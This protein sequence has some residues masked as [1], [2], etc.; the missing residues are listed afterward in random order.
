MT[1]DPQRSQRGAILIAAMVALAIIA[2]TLKEIVTLS[3]EDADTVHLQR[4]SDQNRSYM[5]SAENLIINLLGQSDSFDHELMWAA[6]RGH[7]ILYPLDDGGMLTIQ[8]KDD[9]QCL[10]L[11]QF[12]AT[13]TPTPVQGMFKSK[14]ELAEF[15]RIVKKQLALLPSFGFKSMN[16]RAIDL[17]TVELI[18]KLADWIDADSITRTNGAETPQYMRDTPSRTAANELMADLSEI[19]L[20]QPYSYSR[21]AGLLDLAWCALPTTDDQGIGIN[22]I[23]PQTLPLLAAKLEGI[24]SVSDIKRW[25]E[26]YNGEIYERR[27]D[28][29]EAI[30]GESVLNLN[31]APADVSKINRG[32]SIHPKYITALIAVRSHNTTSFYES[33]MTIGGSDR[34][35]YLRR[36]LP[37][38]PIRE[39]ED[40]SNL[41]FDGN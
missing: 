3:K 37:Y 14:E 32:L 4:G 41:K 30:A 33:R 15:P 8:V 25:Y 36:E 19:N 9:H 39:D 6:L 12:Y 1:K 7:P 11:N 40:Y 10:N 27:T 5:L 35:A 26:Q 20:L 21:H 29:L 17:S 16:E 31:L 38:N 24:V 23:R 2:F 22:N 18:D 34:G 28:L 13:S